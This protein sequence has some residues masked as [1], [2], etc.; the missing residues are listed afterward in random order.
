MLYLIE[1]VRPHLGDAVLRNM[2]DARKRVFVDLLG[3]DVPVRAGR[4]EIDQ[5][6]TPNAIYLVLAG[7]DGAHRA[8]A[9]LLPTTRP[10]ILDTM[11]ACLCDGPPPRGET[12]FEITRFCLERSLST[13]ERRA[14]RN[15]LVSALAR[16]GANNRITLYTGVAEQGWMEQVLAFGW[17]AHRLGAP[18]NIAGSRL[19]AIA[20]EID[21]ETPA[22]LERAGICGTPSFVGEMPHAA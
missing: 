13:R 20:I 14:T 16:F 7:A 21:A 1:G 9:R 17:R 11:F 4:F 6:D 2:F 3:W 8:S 18:R 10:H 5:F 15:E 12:I 22:L 19:G